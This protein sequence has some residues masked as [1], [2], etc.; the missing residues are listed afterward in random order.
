MLI[1]IKSMA[2][3]PPTGSVCLPR[4]PF[5]PELNHW[6]Y[7][8]FWSLVLLSA[9]SCCWRWDWKNIQSEFSWPTRKDSSYF[10]ARNAG[11]MGCSFL[12]L[13]S[14]GWGIWMIHTAIPC[15][16]K[17]ETNTIATAAEYKVNRQ[18]DAASDISHRECCPQP[19]RGSRTNGVV[20]RFH[21]VV[22]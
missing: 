18:S 12:L 9:W 6:N 10:K 11:I 1:F 5:E 15:I 3:L 17:S 8:L 13:F 21:W 4:I 14:L 7:P 22:H 2:T 20:D 16:S 19:T